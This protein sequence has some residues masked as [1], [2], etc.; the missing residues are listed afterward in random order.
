MNWRPRLPACRKIILPARLHGSGRDV[1]LQH[2][3]L[4]APELLMRYWLVPFGSAGSRRTISN[5]LW[6]ALN[7][8]R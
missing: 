2:N 6:L 3:P 5:E 8:T 7:R 4:T 1:V